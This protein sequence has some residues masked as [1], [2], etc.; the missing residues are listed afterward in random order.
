MSWNGFH[1]GCPLHGHATIDMPEQEPDTLC[2][3]EA[4]LE[5]VGQAAPKLKIG[6]HVWRIQGAASLAYPY[7]PEVARPRIITAVIRR[8]HGISYFTK[9]GVGGDERIEQVAEDRLFIHEHLAEAEAD[10][11]HT[12]WVATLSR[13]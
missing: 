3:C 11:R 8:E 10:R 1:D 7:G 9:L 2:I 4:I 12:A 6:D 5:A 13:R